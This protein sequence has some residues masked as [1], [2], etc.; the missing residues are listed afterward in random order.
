MDSCLVASLERHSIPQIRISNCQNTAVIEAE[1]QT[2]SATGDD[3]KTL[4][5]RTKRRTLYIEP[6]I[7]LCFESCPPWPSGK[8][9]MSPPDRW[10]LYRPLPTRRT[11]RRR[12]MSHEARENRG[13]P[14]HRQE[15]RAKARHHPRCM[16]TKDPRETFPTMRRSA[17]SILVASRPRSMPT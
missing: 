15:N 3:S 7:S 12:E 2:G 14:S 8:Q 17:Y 5:V 4:T 1:H 13:V 6:L 10:H 9:R 11:E 16:G